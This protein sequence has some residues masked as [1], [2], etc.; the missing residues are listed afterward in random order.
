[1]KHGVVIAIALFVFLSGKALALDE[2]PAQSLA[3]EDRIKVIEAAETCP[4]SFDIMNAC[5]YNASGDVELT[6]IV[7]KKCEDR[8][9]KKLS[10]RKRRSYEGER[11]ACKQRYAHEEGTMYVSFA[12]TCEA[13]VAVKYEKRWGRTTAPKS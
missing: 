5:R 13:G 6:E 3:R 11:K 4:A 9:L 8:F 7:I 12:V 1:M 10:A 2:C